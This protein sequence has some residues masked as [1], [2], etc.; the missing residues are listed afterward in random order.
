MKIKFYVLIAALSL[1]SGCASTE[2]AIST[3]WDS[4]STQAEVQAVETAAIQVAGAFVSSLVAAPAPGAATPPMATND[5]RVLAAES[6]EVA[7]LQAQYPDAPDDALTS[8]V[9]DSFDKAIA[10]HNATLAK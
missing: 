4:P 8:I 1:G 7:S 3:W 10:S 2:T 5:P 6:A 9:S